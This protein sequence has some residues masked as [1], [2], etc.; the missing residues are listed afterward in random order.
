MWTS[1]LQ[2]AASLSAAAWAGA[3]A[4]RVECP[5]EAWPFVLSPRLYFVCSLSV[6]EVFTS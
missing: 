5:A 4:V 3:G 1:E 2:V 6:F